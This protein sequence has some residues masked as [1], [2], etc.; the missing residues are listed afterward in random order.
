MVATEK[1]KPSRPTVKTE[2]IV[3]AAAELAKRAANSLKE[4]L[5]K[6]EELMSTSETQQLKI[7]EQEEKINELGT[8][9]AEKLRAQEVEFDLKVKADSNKVVKELL[10][11]QNL[12]AVPTEEYDALKKELSDLE[13]D[14]ED[15]TAAAVKKETS[16]AYGRLENEKKLLEANFAAK[17][18]ENRAEIINLKAMNE[19]LREQAGLWKQSLDDERAAGIERAKAGSIG[20]INVGD[21]QGSSKR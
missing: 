1:K 9:Y 17:E 7:A 16:I 8:S 18:A 3:G 20:S 14:F 11:S 6:F 13:K 5:A 2:V 19:Q 10:G 15:E 12:V 4:S 21:S